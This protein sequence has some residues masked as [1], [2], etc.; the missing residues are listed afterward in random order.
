LAGNVNLAPSLSQHHIA[1]RSRVDS[2]ILQGIVGKAEAVSG[3]NEQ[4]SSLQYSPRF[5]IFPP[6]AFSLCRV[7]SESEYR[8]LIVHKIF[9]FVPQIAMRGRIS[10]HV[11][12]FLLRFLYILNLLQYIAYLRV[13]NVLVG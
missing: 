8:L 4:N 12:P 5:H 3:M 6:F 13:Q 10:G 9:S 11:L 2:S 1:Q 7:V